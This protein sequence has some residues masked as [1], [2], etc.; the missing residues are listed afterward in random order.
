MS[1][2]TDI[3][4]DLPPVQEVV[5]GVV[6]APL[7]HLKTAHMGLVWGLFGEEFPKTEDMLPIGHRTPEGTRIDPRPRVW[8]VSE[9]DQRIIQVQ[10]D[11]FHFNWRKVGDDDPYPRFES[12]YA[13]FTRHYAAFRDLI[14]TTE[15]VVPEHLELTYVNI[16]PQGPG[17]PDAL[18]GLFPDLVRSV[19][20]R[21]YLPRPRGFQWTS[22]YDL[23][24]VPAPL[25]ITATTVTR[26]GDAPR[27]AIK[28]ELTVGGP[29]TPPDGAELDAWFD[30][31]H[32]AIVRGFVDITAGETQREVWKRRAP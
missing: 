25:R 11:R 3:D 12:V 2:T 16:L 14:R 20:D 1:R 29:V 23:A 18:A 5:C 17:L 9:D 15:E 27:P 4:F 22:T 10:L 21:R 24:G 30:A 6:F 19:D 7:Q 13:A 8:F 32:E 28:L 26:G 31:A